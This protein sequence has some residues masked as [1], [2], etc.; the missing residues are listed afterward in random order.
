MTRL[1]RRA[2]LAAALLAPVLPAAPAPRAQGA[3][4]G[5]AAR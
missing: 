5:T 1:T 2:G 3:G 4:I